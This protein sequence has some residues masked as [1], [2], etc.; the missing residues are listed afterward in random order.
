V[1]SANV[2]QA[3]E[4]DELAFIDTNSFKSKR[5]APTKAKVVYSSDPTI[6]QGQMNRAN[7]GY[8][9]RVSINEGPT[10]LL[11]V[12]LL[13]YVDS[14]FTCLQACVRG[15]LLPCYQRLSDDSHHSNPHLLSQR[16]HIGGKHVIRLIQHA[17]PKRI[18]SFTTPSFC[19]LISFLI[20]FHENRYGGACDFGGRV[21]W[22][23]QVKGGL[24]FDPYNPNAAGP[25]RNSVGNDIEGA[26]VLVERGVR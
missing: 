19:P 11:Y 24:Y 26:I 25:F 6:R 17:S 7:A 16:H 18:H 20:F 10:A 3:P 13:A 21:A 15:I 5:D 22:N 9:F 14:Y 4:F 2:L 12:P 8:R 23:D 1:A